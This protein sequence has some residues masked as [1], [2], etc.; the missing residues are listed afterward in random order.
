MLYAIAMGQI[1]IV[2]A[3]RLKDIV[4]RLGTVVLV[5]LENWPRKP[6][7]PQN[8]WHYWKAAV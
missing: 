4:R 7:A 3:C 8:S 5:S 2:E 1:I 6:T